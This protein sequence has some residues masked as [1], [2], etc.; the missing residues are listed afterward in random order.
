MAGSSRPGDLP[1][2]VKRLDRLAH[3]TDTRAAVGDDKRD[4]V[5]LR[6]QVD[7]LDEQR[8]QLSLRTPVPAVW[9]QLATLAR[10]LR[11]S[12]H[13]HTPVT[14]TFGGDNRVL[15]NRSLTSVL[16]RYPRP[17]LDRVNT[18]NRQAEALPDG[19][20]IFLYAPDL[21]ICQVILV[22][23]RVMNVVFDIKHLRLV[24]GQPQARWKIPRV[25]AREDPRCPRNPCG[26]TP[27]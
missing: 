19:S 3:E 18:G 23:K 12:P 22:G 6:L 17:D 26:G 27:H 10:V 7:V 24:L 2:P 16:G 21:D 13:P 25:P 11:E 4:V 1:F 20:L 15:L 8:K 5:L 14:R 9:L